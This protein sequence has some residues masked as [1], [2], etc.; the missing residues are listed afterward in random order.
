[1]TPAAIPASVSA[2]TTAASAAAPTA[3]TAPTPVL[4]TALRR[5]GR[6]LPTPVGTPFTFCYALVLIATTVFADLGN[7]TTVSLLLR[8]SSTDVAHLAQ[9]PL[10]VLFASTLWV[11]GGLLS[12]YALGFLLVL[13]ALERRIGGLR[14]AAVFLL[15]H[16]LATL[17][18]ELPVAVAVA[19]GHLPE[20]SLHRL[21]YGIS[22]GLMA[23]TGALAGLLRPWLRWAV[24]GG[25]GA[26]LLSDL[27]EFSD[28]LTNWGHPLSL[29]IGVAAWPL[30]RA[31][32]RDGGLGR[33]SRRAP[34]NSP[35]VPGRDP[36]PS[37]RG[38]RS[39]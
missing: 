7:Q 28:P 17:A 22:F 25:V 21:D 10:L 4:R 33:A 11:A 29:L 15:G 5:L 39:A 9:T 1:M 36:D 37:A 34:L 6:L 3:V 26:M 31:W 32:S 19:V 16:V 2:A 14:T 8:G 23:S 24:L 30:V 13:T 38:P 18:T 27:V 35:Q 20:A 12:P